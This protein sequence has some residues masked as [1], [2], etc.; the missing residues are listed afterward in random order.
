MD[1]DKFNDGALF[2]LAAKLNG[3]WSRGDLN[4]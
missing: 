3:W 1:G 4:P 2:T